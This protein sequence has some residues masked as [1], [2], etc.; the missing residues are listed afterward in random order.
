[1]ETG[2]RPAEIVEVQTAAL[3]RFRA[4]Q[5]ERYLRGPI[6]MAD[7]QAAAKLSGPCLAL[8]L[9][10]HYRHAITK[11]TV[12]TLPSGIL[13]DFGIDKS[14]KRRALL[15]LESAKLIRVTR[16]PGK[17]AAV[18]LMARPP[19]CR[20]GRLEAAPHPTAKTSLQTKIGK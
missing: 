8:L 9:A 17:T 14:A 11:Q 3:R 6:R 19:P 5:A 15:R 13:S 7:I 4:R 20:Q 1:M 18:E 16:D 10:I 12:V 2:F